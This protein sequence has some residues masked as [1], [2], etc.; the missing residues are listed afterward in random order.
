MERISP[1]LFKCT[2]TKAFYQKKVVQGTVNLKKGVSRKQSTPNFR[3]NKH[4]WPP[5]THTYLCVSGGN[6]CSFFGKFDVLCLYKTPVLRFALLPYYR[7]SIAIC[8]GI[9]F[10]EWLSPAY[11]TQYVGKGSDPIFFF[12]QAF[13]KCHKKF[14]RGNLV[15]KF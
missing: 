10:M 9:V 7:R 6:K 4:V 1:I 15:M 5:D 13:P 3:K 8:H 14:Y 2:Q 11:T 12:F